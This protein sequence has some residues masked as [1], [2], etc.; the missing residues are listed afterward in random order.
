MLGHF[1]GYRH[2]DISYN[3]Q[4]KTIFG[5]GAG[6]VVVVIRLWGGL[7]EGVSYSILMM[8][9]ITPLINRFTRPRIFGK[10]R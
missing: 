2:G 9:G 7:P 4:R 10:G 6:I 5:I 3:T 8:N 1:H